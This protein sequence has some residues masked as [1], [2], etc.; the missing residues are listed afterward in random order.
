MVGLANLALASFRV[1]FGL[2]TW[3]AWLCFVYVGFGFGW[4][5]FGLFRVW[6][7]LALVCS[8]FGG[9]FLLA[10]VCKAFFGFRLLVVALPPCML[11]LLLFSGSV[12]RRHW[13]FDDC[14]V[15]L[16][17]QLVK[18]CAIFPKSSGSPAF[19][20]VRGTPATRATLLASCSIGSVQTVTLGGVRVC[21]G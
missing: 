4:L 3:Q 11:G 19:G 16:T 9:L 14:R 1:W 7:G 20:F 21:R 8:G 15:L 13:D 17:S 5:G 12:F 2:S 10:L 18:L 6:F